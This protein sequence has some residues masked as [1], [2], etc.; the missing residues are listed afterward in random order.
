MTASFIEDVFF[1]IADPVH[2]AHHG[3]KVTRH[4]RGSNIEI[5]QL[6]GV[7]VEKDVDAT[8]LREVGFIVDDTGQATHRAARFDIPAN[9]DASEYDIWVVD[10]EE[11]KAIGVQVGDDRSRKTVYCKI[12]RPQVARQPSTQR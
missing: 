3:R 10:G 7:I 6:E 11:W 1:K 12:K 4:I 5:Q 2:A 9:I 8:T